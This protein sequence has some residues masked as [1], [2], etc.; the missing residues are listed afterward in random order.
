MTGSGYAVANDEAEHKALTAYGY[1]PAFVEAEAPT[2][3][4]ATLRAQLDAKG[5]EYDM[6]WGGAKLREALGA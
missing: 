4:K 3:E 1:E 5:I 6:R 2:D